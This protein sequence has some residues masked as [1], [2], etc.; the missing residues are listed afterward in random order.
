MGDGVEQCSKDPA[1]QQH[2]P[3]HLRRA[4]VSVVAMRRLRGS[5]EGRHSLPPGE[6][7]TRGPAVTF[8]II[9]NR[10][11]AVEALDPCLSSP[12]LR[13]LTRWSRLETRPQVSICGRL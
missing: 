5:I 4:L 7:S 1:G 2:F 11:K 13:W 12:F 10:G 9:W 3:R 6:S 8:S